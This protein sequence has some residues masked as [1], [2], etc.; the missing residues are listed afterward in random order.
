MKN[1]RTLDWMYLM[2]M[3]DSIELIDSDRLDLYN[4][5]NRVLKIREIILDDFK[6]RIY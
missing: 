2:G 4:T 5:Y 6:E 1:N 3:L